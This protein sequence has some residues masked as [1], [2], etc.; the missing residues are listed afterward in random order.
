MAAI[1]LHIL[2]GADQVRDTGREKDEEEYRGPGVG[3]VARA[4]LGAGEAD[5]LAHGAG[6]AR[7]GLVQVSQGHPGRDGVG[8][9]ILDH[10]VLY[11]GVLHQR[12]RGARLVLDLRRL[13]RHLLVELL[14]SVHGRHEDL[15]LDR[16]L[17]GCECG[18]LMLLLRHGWLGLRDGYYDWLLL[19]LLLL[20]LR[21][22]WL[23]LC[24]GY[25]NGLLLLLLGHDWL[26]L[27]GRHQNGLLLLLLHY[28]WL[29]LCLG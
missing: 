23:G 17:E 28:E 8:R 7:G 6:H 2:Q 22:G 27:C 15:A 25:Y 1:M 16:L 19:L 11:H 12:C 20:L 21:H 3:G 18:L 5:V 10:G 4:Q 13:R 14:L 29:G 9:L 26:G 24:D